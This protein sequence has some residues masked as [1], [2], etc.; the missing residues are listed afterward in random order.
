MQ[1]ERQKSKKVKLKN[2]LEVHFL[3]D[4]LFTTSSLQMCFKV[5]WRHDKEEQRG[6]AHLFEHLVGK[7][8]KRFPEKSEFSKKLDE[9]GIVT[10]ATTGPDNTIYYQNQTN[11]NLI[12]SLSM[13]YESIYGSVF[14]QDDLEKEKNVVLTEAREYLDNDD[15]VIW[16]QMMRNLFPK[17]TMEK[18]FF[19][20]VETMKNITLADFEEFYNIYKNPKNSILFVATNSIKNKKKV[21][22]FLKKFYSEADKNLFSKARVEPAIDKAAQIISYSKIDKPDR[23]QSNLRVGF[24]VHKFNKRERVMFSVIAS[25]LVGGFSGTLMQRLRDDMGLVYGIHLGRNFFAYDFCYIMFSTSC[26]KSNTEMVVS[27]IKEVIEDTRE[28]LVQ[29]DIDR[30]VP[31]RIYYQKTPPQAYEDLCE[32]VD[33]VF[34]EHDYIQTEESLEILKTIKV[35]EVKKM[36][37]KIFNED[38][39]SVC[40][41]E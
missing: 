13:M 11:D 19:G 18:F 28:R 40:V 16:R 5:G 36:M 37:E 4:K 7:R 38:N 27:K 9:L 8:T 33:A 30:T 23:I 34:Y 32:F 29:K 39:K 35:E 14:T 26:E 6:L 41:L 1:K 15:S 31:L 17:T 22:D 3:F 2:G 25:V 21:L 20:D 12:E 24:V 10:N